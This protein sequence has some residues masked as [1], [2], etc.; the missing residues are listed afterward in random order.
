MQGQVA[1]FRI[2]LRLGDG[3]PGGPTCFEDIV[4]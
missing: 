1:S 4:A 2:E 3:S